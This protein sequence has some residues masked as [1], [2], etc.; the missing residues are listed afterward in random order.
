MMHSDEAAEDYLAKGFRDVDAA[1]TGKMAKCLAFVDSNPSF[2]RYKASILEAMDLRRGSIAADLGCGLGF[3][4]CRIS[5]LV[6]PEGRAIG[7]DASLAL[8][9]SARAASQELSAVEFVRADIQDLPFQTGFLDSC[10]VDRTLQHVERPAS[11]VSEMFRTVRPGGMA[12]CA[13]P[14]WKTFIIHHENSTWMQKIAET[15][16][17]G[18]RHPWIGRQLSN[19]LEK[20]G[21]VDINVRS[22]LLTTP[23][24]E[25]SDVVFDLTQTALRL[26]ANSGSQEPLEWLANVRERDRIS[27]VCSSVELLMNSARRP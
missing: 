21:F 10:K 18:F 26:S 13:E 19:E 27:P 11:V 1:A 22:F 24:F 7:V 25:S 16:S 14:D 17:E 23:S 5:R 9:E 12:V 6:G 8:I 20:A 3:D 2:Q 15:W 4:V